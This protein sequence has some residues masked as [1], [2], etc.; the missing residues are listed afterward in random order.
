MTTSLYDQFHSEKNIDHVFELLNKL[1]LQKSGVTIKNNTNY[2]NYYKKSLQDIFIK[3]NNDTI[4]ELNREVL[5]YNLR[6]F[7]NILKMNPDNSNEII[8]TNVIDDY[9]K[10]VESRNN[11]LTLP[12]IKEKSNI[13]STIQENKEEEEENKN[14]L[15][16]KLDVIILTIENV[17]QNMYN[18]YMVHK[19][20]KEDIDTIFSKMIKEG[21][22]FIEIPRDTRDELKYE[23][24]IRVGNE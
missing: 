11:E 7:L 18:Y 20:N 8:E 5:T 22:S 21:Y 10:F 9:N 2:V 24:N 16:Y 13:T 23:L 17:L 12:S 3:S 6:Y 14:E 1:I 19:L 15:I 4:E